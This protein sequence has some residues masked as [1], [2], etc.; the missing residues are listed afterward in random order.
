[1][2][3]T[4]GQGRASIPQF[5]AGD[6]ILFA[7]EGDLYSKVGGWLMRDRGEGPTYAVHTAHFIDPRR[8]LEMDF[9]ARIKSV[10]DV[11]NRR[12]RFDM[13]KRRGFEVWRCETL[14]DEQRQALTRQSLA[15]LN[16]KFGVARFGAHLLD[17]LIGK[18][19]RRQFFYFRRMDPEDRSPVCSGITASVYDRAL[20]Y[21]FGVEPECADPDHI[22]DWVTTHPGEWARVF[23]LEAY[24][25]ATARQTSRWAAALNLCMEYVRSARR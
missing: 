16:A 12:Y 3:S 23:R 15:Y 24:S 25:V 1:M 20:H 18:L 13:W 6:V 5:R 21:R 11:L 17:G 7:G 10:D 22:Y 14:T 8:V 2:E 9:V 19:A 4:N